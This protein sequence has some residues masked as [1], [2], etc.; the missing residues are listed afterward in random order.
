MCLCVSMH[1]YVYILVHILVHIGIFMI[2]FICLKECAFKRERERGGA[3]FS[4]FCGHIYEGIW[5]QIIVYI[6]MCMFLCICEG[7]V[8]KDMSTWLSH[9]LTERDRDK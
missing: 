5:V 8:Y 2:M 7:V 3:Y 4:I 6:Y 9:S 1:V